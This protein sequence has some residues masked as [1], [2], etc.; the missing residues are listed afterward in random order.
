MTAIARRPSA[1]PASRY[2]RA[3]IVPRNSF[4][5]APEATEARG[6]MAR[7][8]RQGEW[9]FIPIEKEVEDTIDRDIARGKLWV[10]RRASIGRFIPRPGKGHRADELVVVR[11]D[12]K[13]EVYVRGR[14][15]HVD[16]KIVRFPFWVRVY[17][18]RE[19][20]EQASPFGGGWID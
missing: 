17:R 1:R 14:V 20:L 10:Y 8:I 2:Q 19:V 18:N 16:H 3:P 15:L 6:V 7:T 11:D 9:F 4:Q 13:Q 5:T 12:G